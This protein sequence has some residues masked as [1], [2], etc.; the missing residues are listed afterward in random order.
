MPELIEVTT[1]SVAETL[2]VGEVFS[3]F[4]RRGDAVA[5]IGDLGSGKTVFVRGVAAGLGYSGLVTSPTFTLIHEYKATITIYHLDCFR[6][7]QPTEVLSLGL[8][9]LQG[10][11]WV[12]LAEWADKIS[13]HFNQWIWILNFKF[14]Q[15]EDNKRQIQFRTGSDPVTY[16]RLE[17]LRESLA[18]L[19]VGAL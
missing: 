1:D 6:L 13:D 17:E 15:S 18:E 14:V 10:S 8:D 12:I 2:R 16:Q 5:L 3:R 4:L 7:R 11:E 19:P 9:D